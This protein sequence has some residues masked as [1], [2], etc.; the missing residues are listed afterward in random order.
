M[1]KKHQ[2][3]LNACKNCLKVFRTEGETKEFCSKDCEEEYKEW[4]GKVGSDG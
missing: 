4:F 2:R 1:N 3:Y